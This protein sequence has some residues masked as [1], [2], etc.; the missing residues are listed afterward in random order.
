MYSEIQP[1]RPVAYWLFSGCVM[2]AIILVVGGLTRLNDAGLSITEWDVIGGVIPPMSEAGWQDAFDTYRAF[3]EYQE[4]NAGMSMSEFK[5]I[6]WW[7]YAHRMLARM[8]GFLFLIPFLIF[9]WQRRFSVPEYGK[10]TSIFM[11]GALQG[12]IGWYMV[13]SGLAGEPYVSHLRLAMH[14]G[15]AFLIFGMTLRFGL[16]K[17]LGK[18]TLPQWTPLRKA[19]VAIGAL[20]FIQV[21]LGALTAGLNA[22][23]VYP[24]FP[25]MGPHWIPP[26]IGS[27]S[28]LVYDLFNNMVTVQFL[29]RMTAY[30]LVVVSLVFWYRMYRTVND[31]TIRFYGHLFL[32][33]VVAQV[34]AGVFTLLLFIPNWLAVLHQFLALMLFTIIVIMERM[35]ARNPTVNYATYA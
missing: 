9:A 13:Q 6:Y 14:L 10:L 35:F 33:L 16:T 12:F 3:P 20:L 19:T 29:H 1:D 30:L 5:M 7:E 15:L 2:I 27:L 22:G 25:K 21:L 11:V 23:Y 31:A 4:L 8:L 18:A 32:A 24:T 34:A 28:P 17:F 26:E